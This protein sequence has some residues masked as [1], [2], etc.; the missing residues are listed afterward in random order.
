[1]ANKTESR[2]SQSSC[3]NICITKTEPPEGS[4]FVM[5]SVFAVAVLDVDE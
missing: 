4:V 2:L 5:Q 3:V 1:M